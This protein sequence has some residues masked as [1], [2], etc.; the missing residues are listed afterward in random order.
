M[1]KIETKDYDSPSTRRTIVDLE[2]GVCAGSAVFKNV[3]D[4]KTISQEI[5]T[6]FDYSFDPNDGWEQVKQKTDA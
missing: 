4:V 6:N 3:A 2:D 5:E 1:L